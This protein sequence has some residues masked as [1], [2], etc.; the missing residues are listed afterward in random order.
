MLLK[1]IYD[2]KIDR[3][4]NPAVVVSDKK[5]E[6]IEAEIGEY[7]FTNELIEKL[8]EIVDTVLNKRTGKSGIWIN[9]YYGSGKF[10]IC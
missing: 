6:T 8:Y 10:T 4:I 1:E 5:S 2:R 7:V 3:E 9:G